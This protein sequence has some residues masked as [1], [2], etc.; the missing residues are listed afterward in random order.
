M[1]KKLVALLFLSAPVLGFSFKPYLGNGDTISSGTITNLTATTMTV[2][3]VTVG[4]LAVTTALTSLNDSM[5][6]PGTSGQA[7]LSRGAS[8]GPQWLP[9][10]ASSV[11][12]GLAPLNGTITTT[13]TILQ[14]FNKIVNARIVQIACY[15]QA[16]NDTTTSAS[17]ATTSS[18]VT[19]NPQLASNKI[20]LIA[21]S[22]LQSVTQNT[23]A[24]AT[25]ARGDMGI[26]LGPVGGFCQMNAVTAGTLTAPCAMIYLDSPGVTTNVGYRV[27]FK[28]D[29]SH[30][31]G[32]G[33]AGQET[34]CAIEIGQ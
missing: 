15:S 33:N 24:Y 19:L 26:N 8:L 12:T 13:D 25:L 31:V 18:T 6:S 16:I 30:T 3:N 22:T 20:L 27:Q 11:L 5:L 14:A 10:G 23:I 17:Y 4:T 32:Y 21:A 29:G 2:N 34:L 1:I 7:L 28:S 9:S